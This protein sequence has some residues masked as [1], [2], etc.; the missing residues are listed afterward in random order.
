MVGK[1]KKAMRIN[2][3]ASVIRNLTKFT[4]NGK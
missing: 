1:I 4:T 2:R 3:E